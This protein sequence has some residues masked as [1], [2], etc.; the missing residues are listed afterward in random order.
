M[1]PPVLSCVQLGMDCSAPSKAD[2]SGR[3]TH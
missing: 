1:I 3:A 2:A